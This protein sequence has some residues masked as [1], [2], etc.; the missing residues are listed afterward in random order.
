MKR[1]LWPV[2]IVLI[3]IVLFSGF[4]GMEDG[5]AQG[6]VSVSEA[7]FAVR[8]SSCE[9]VTSFLVGC[10]DSDKGT[11][12]RFDG[13]GGVIET[14]MNLDTREGTALLTQTAGGT[15]LLQLSVGDS[16]QLYTFQLV[17]AEGAFTLT[18]ADGG[19]ETFQP[20]L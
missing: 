11:R 6:P 20:V 15:A 8:T 16:L 17:S 5:V 1:L 4:S 13:A 9:D 2:C 14:S 10:F 19:S 7:A 12:L 3:A 18:D